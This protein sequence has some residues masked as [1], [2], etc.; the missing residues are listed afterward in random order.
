MEEADP[1][2]LH[3]YE[4]EDF[5]IENYDCPSRSKNKHWASLLD[6]K[7]L[8]S[9]ILV[10]YLHGKRFDERIIKIVKL[11]LKRGQHL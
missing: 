3:S 2:M 10:H 8:D 11:M 4:L 1:R 5:G 7:R 9:R 6:E